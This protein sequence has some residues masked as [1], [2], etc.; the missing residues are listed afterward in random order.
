MSCT[1]SLNIF[2]YSKNDQGD[3][4]KESEKFFHK[5]SVRGNDQYYTFD[6]TI[7]SRMDTLSMKKNCAWWP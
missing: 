5:Q 3:M 6:L 7:D 1:T 4:L 2:V